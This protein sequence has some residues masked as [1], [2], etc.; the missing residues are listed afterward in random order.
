M[1]FIASPNPKAMKKVLYIMLFLILGMNLT[2]QS[3]WDGSREA[4]SSGSGTESDPYLIENAQQLAW[5]VYLI[6]W[7]YS[8]WTSGKYFLLT[9]DIE[10]NGSADNQW[11]PIGAG[12]SVDSHKYFEGVFDGG[13]HSITG[14]YIDADNPINNNSDMWVSSYAGFFT[15]LGANAVVKNRYLE[16]S[17]TSGRKAGGFAGSSYGVFEYCVSNVN[18]ESTAQ[19]AA[20]I[21]SWGNATVKF[22]ANL[23]NIRGKNGAGGIVAWNGTVENCYNKG[24]IEAEDYIGGIA[25]RS[26]RIK[27]CYNIGDVLYSSNATHVGAIVGIKPSGGSIDNCYYLD[28]CIASTNEY[29]V[30]ETADFMRSQEFVNMLNNGITIWAMDTENVN[31]GYPVFDETFMDVSEIAENTDMVVVYPN[32][33]VDNVYVVGD[34]ASCEIYDLVGKRVTGVTFDIDKIVVTDL[35]SGIYMMRFVTNNGNVVTKKIIKK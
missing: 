25:G 30:P 20:G 31:D 29:G 32:P 34:V 4:I 16:G 13:F 28:G 5:L 17:V 24:N 21:V 14:I 6:N 11:I 7:D 26:M 27:N 10:L 15:E 3:V 33:V 1:R 12:P 35:P 18:V 22:C 8:R 9:T 23:G 2:A 19:T